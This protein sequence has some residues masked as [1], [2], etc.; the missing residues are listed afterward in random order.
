MT[1]K[2]NRFHNL[3]KWCLIHIHQDSQIAALQSFLKTLLLALE[4]KCMWALYYTSS[5]GVTARKI[6]LYTR[7]VHNFLQRAKN[8]H[9]KA[10]VGHQSLLTFLR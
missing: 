3:K 6:N 2:K 7:C 10:P 5:W 1:E 4:V 9:I 8:Y